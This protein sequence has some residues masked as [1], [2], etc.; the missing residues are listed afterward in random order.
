MTSSSGTCPVSVIVRWRQSCL[1]CFLTTGH[2]T[3]AAVDQRA[4]VG[5]VTDYTTKSPPSRCAKGLTPD[6]LFSLPH[7]PTDGYMGGG[8]VDGLRHSIWP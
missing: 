7:V 2:I 8:L 1:I 5:H 3:L 4:C 6:N